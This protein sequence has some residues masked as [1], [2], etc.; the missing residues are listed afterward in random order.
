M[1]ILIVDDEYDFRLTMQAL[2]ELYG[3]TVET[4]CNGVDALRIATRRKP[5]V[6]LL[7]L[8]MPLMNGFDA[9]QKFRE[10]WNSTALLIVS[11]SAYVSDREW[12]VRALASGADECLPKPFDYPRFESIVKTWQG[13]LTP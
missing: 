13:G 9:A 5:D 11:V 7:D 4:A 12:C 10:K 2:L 6:V 1:H 8:N 3:H